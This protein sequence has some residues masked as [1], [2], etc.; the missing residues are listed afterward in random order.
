[1]ANHFMPG[2]VAHTMMLANRLLPGINEADGDTK[3]RGAES[4]SRWAPSVATVLTEKAAV[5]NN[6]V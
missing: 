1:V 6:E 4:T 2:V 5:V 3:K